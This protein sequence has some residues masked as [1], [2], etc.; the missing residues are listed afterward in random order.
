MGL[1]GRV[2]APIGEDRFT[3]KGR[4]MHVHYFVVQADRRLPSWSDH[5]GRDT[6][7]FSPAE[8]RSRLTH[9]GTRAVLEQA[10]AQFGRSR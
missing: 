9:A 3:H 7:L 2:I 1:A 5:F 8:A 6:F 4:T 10:L